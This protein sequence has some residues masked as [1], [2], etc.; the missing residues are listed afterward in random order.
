MNRVTTAGN[1]AAMPILM[2]ASETLRITG[3]ELRIAPAHPKSGQ[4]AIGQVKGLRNRAT[5]VPTPPPI[6]AK[7]P[8]SGKMAV[9]ADAWVRLIPRASWKYCGRNAVWS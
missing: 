3:S 8:V 5:A 1:G 7:I 6:E 9:S 4:H 2:S